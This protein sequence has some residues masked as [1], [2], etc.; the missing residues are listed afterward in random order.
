MK[1]SSHD[2]RPLRQCLR[3]QYT[4]TDGDTAVQAC[5]CEGYPCTTNSHSQNTPCFWT[6]DHYLSSLQPL[7]FFGKSEELALTLASAYLA[8]KY[9]YVEHLR[10]YFPIAMYDAFS[11]AVLNLYLL[12]I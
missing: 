8:H 5:L 3:I 11:H 10:T 9:T 7:F 1:R 6:N 2:D 12:T 4:L